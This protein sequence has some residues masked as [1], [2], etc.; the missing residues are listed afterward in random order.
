MS[1]ITGLITP[2]D[3]ERARHEIGPALIAAGCAEGWRSTTLTAGAAALGWTGWRAPDVAEEGGCLVV[4]D[5]AIVN[6][7]DLAADGIAPRCPDA[8]ALLALYRR[9]GFVEAMRRVAGDLAA[10]LYDA[11]TG[12]LWL[13][14]DRIGVKPLYWAAGPDEFAF[15]SRPAAL[16]A[17]P[18]VDGGVN[19]RFVA[20]FAGSHYRSI[21]NAPEESP[22]AAIA[23]VPAGTVLEVRNGAVRS[24]RYWTLEEQPDFAED[25]ATLAGRLRELLF[26]SVRRRVALARRPAFTLSGG[27]DSSSVL[28]C[29]VAGSGE[30]LPAYS[31]TYLD[32]TYDETAEIRP[33][34]AEKV[35]R[36]TPV[37]IGDRFDII[38]TIR[39]M[40]RIHDEPV[41][42]A[43]WLSHHRLAG[44][45]AADGHG[46]L[47]GGLGG[48]ELNAGEYE[49]FFFHFADLRATGDTAALGHEIA[50]W[51][52]HHDHPIHR[53]SPAVA[54]AALA[55]MTDPA[56][57]GRCRPDQRRLMRYAAAVDPAW[58]DLSAWQPA[59]DHPFRS[60]LKNRTYQDIFRETAPCCLRAEDRQT[61]AA[62]LDRFDPFFDHRLVE[63][64]FRV[65]GHL[66]IRDGVTKRL[67]RE[68]MRGIL[69]EET[70]TRVKKTG[71]NAP[72]H[73]WFLDEGAAALADLVAS[74][75]FREL[76]VYKVPE[77]ERLLAEHREIVT[78]GVARENHMMFFWQLANLAVWLGA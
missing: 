30:R 46:A 27:L 63:F 20:L 23:Q 77:V 13:G 37:P 61:T 42:T 68:A 40:V 45:V 52:R 11:A 38:A 14:R 49:Y 6:R 47:F 71:W 9:H 57:P 74:R 70:R 21:D 3:P 17:L 54:E 55:L 29:A 51:A 19:R 58:F 67:L 64:M 31:S 65:P 39:E 4:M 53:K 2:R 50:C 78:S 36:W 24:S 16:L 69:P 48:D 75:R 26:D 60:C 76:G 15:A 73:L 43:T 44:Q 28:S 12:T 56:V 59:M 41:A 66:K 32:P 1:R 8:Q 22:Y 62:G 7:D 33:M 72:A 10:A 18:W 25:E 34:L 35:S 5:G